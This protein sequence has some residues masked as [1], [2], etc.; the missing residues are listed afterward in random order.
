[1]I[2]LLRHGET[3]WS[4]AGRKQGRSDSALTPS[5]IAQ[6]HA[7]GRRLAR[8]VA[9]QSSVQLISSPLGRAR[10][11][12]EI[13]R[14]YLD[15]PNRQF[16]VS[17]ALAEHD[18]GSWAGLT[19]AEI[20]QQFP[21]QLAIRKRQHWNY[22]V[23]N[24]ES[25]ALVAQRVHPWLQSLDPHQTVIAVAHDMVSRVLRGLY[26][27]LKPEETLC[28]DLHPHTRIYVLAGGLVQ[29]IDVEPVAA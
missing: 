4:R 8:E 2:Y 18:Y 10:S 22:A 7:C 15:V 28:L 19:N 27:K 13:I 5:G 14:S 12:A 16:T 21:G 1:V 24:G 17:E 9:G 26:L 23:P 6:V 3:E 20:E 29:V 11:S 25:Y